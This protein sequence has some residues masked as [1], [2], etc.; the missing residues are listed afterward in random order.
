M[1]GTQTLVA[2]ATVSKGQHGKRKIN[3]NSTCK[4]F[5]HLSFLRTHTCM[6]ARACV[7]TPTALCLIT[8]HESLNLYNAPPTVWIIIITSFR[9]VWLFLSP[10]LFSLSSSHSFPFPPFLFPLLV[11]LQQW[12]NYSLHTHALALSLSHTHT[13]SDTGGLEK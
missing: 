8:V 13:R 3:F 7:W 1:C 9:A 10:T 2:G 4:E 12:G 11:F 6:C 5:F